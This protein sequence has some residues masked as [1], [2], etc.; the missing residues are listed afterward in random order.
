MFHCRLC[1]APAGGFNAGHCGGR[2]MDKSSADLFGQ[3][4]GCRL[5]AEKLKCNARNLFRF[6]SQSGVIN[7]TRKSSGSCVLRQGFGYQF[8]HPAFRRTA[9]AASKKQSG[10]ELHQRVNDNAT[11]HGL[12]WARKN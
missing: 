12:T 5:N 4:Y 2:Y 8:E 11:V 9:L 6:T 3:N 10:S 7:A 1:P